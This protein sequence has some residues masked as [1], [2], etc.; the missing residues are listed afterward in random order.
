[1]ADQAA[2]PLPQKSVADLRYMLALMLG[3]DPDGPQAKA[4]IFVPMSDSW[5]AMSGRY[6]D[7]PD[8]RSAVIRRSIELAQRY[9][10]ES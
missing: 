8:Y 4:I 2:E 7:P 10:L 6:D 1:M 9:D 3:I 5:R